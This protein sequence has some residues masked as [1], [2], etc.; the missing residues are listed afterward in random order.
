MRTAIRWSFVVGFV[1]AG[2]LESNVAAEE[3]NIRFFLLPDKS[4]VQLSIYP[5]WKYKLKGQLEDGPLII[6]MEGKGGPSFMVG[7]TIIGLD[8]QK[9][10]VPSN[11]QIRENVQRFVDQ[12][13]SN[14]VEKTIE[15]KELKGT[16]GNGY[17]FS[18][19]DSMPKSGAYKYITHGM[20]KVGRSLLAFSVLNND[21]Q[22]I[23]G[24]RTLAMVKSAIYVNRETLLGENTAEE[25][26]KKACKYEMGEGVKKDLE[27]ALQYYMIAA[28]QG[29]PEAMYRLAY[30]YDL[31]GSDNQ[32][33]KLYMMSALK[34]YPEAQAEMG[35]RCKNGE[36]VAKNPEQAVKWMTSAATQG[37]VSAM[38][39]L[40]HYYENGIGVPQN[41]EQ[42]IRWIKAAANTGDDRAMCDLGCA[43][44]NGKIIPRNYPE[45]KYWL[46]KSALAGNRHGLNIL[47]E[48]RVLND[49]IYN[50]PLSMIQCRFMK[51]IAGDDIFIVNIGDT[52][53]KVL[54]LLGPPGLKGRSG[55]PKD[56]NVEWI[57]DWDYSFGRISFKNGKVVEANVNRTTDAGKKKIS[58]SGKLYDLEAPPFLQPNSP[59]YR[60]LA[61]SA[62]LTELNHGRHDLL[63]T[64][65]PTEENIRHQ[66]W[67]L[68]R[69]W[70]VTSRES[71][72]DSLRW[73]YEKG[74]RVNFNNIVTYSEKLT[75]AQMNA[76]T[77]TDRNFAV[78]MKYKN[79]LGKKSILG[80]DF[81]RYISL[82]RWGYL[83][84]YLSEEEAWANIMPVAK[85]LQKTFNS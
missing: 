7:V 30:I 34:G 81:A 44:Y 38:L 55:I 71:F 45:G 75:P 79:E 67:L 66:L 6:E 37:V 74:H 3:C 4:G 26:R 73:I 83:V 78:V 40:G 20:I 31:E 42:A 14:A 18:A 1:L 22:E 9:I 39:A 69:W 57:D 48:S 56:G 50:W 10:P 13:K 47:Q 65:M 70:S 61:S 36:G 17:Y 62:L 59:K 64:E 15:V 76:A 35:R 60:A 21:G 27:L 52:S 8:S 46:F 49:F 53:N 68:Y 58:A 85:L 28:E 23:I 80:W 77:A 5:S 33:I 16:S 51:E 19:T 11:E 29:D 82:C 43:Y 32:S 84:G 24:S 25:N 72:L 63:G 41:A 2:F 12:V 54:S